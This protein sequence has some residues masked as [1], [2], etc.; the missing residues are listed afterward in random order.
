MKGYAAIELSDHAERKVRRILTAGW[1][2]LAACWVVGAILVV[3]GL[4]AKP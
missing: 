4:T 1:A 2:L 3:V